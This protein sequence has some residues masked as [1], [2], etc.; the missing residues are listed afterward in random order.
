MC[1]FFQIKTHEKIAANFD[2]IND[3]IRKTVD[4]LIRVVQNS[5]DSEG[6]T[7]A[8]GSNSISTSNS[9]L[10]SSSNSVSNGIERTRS[11]IQSS[12][13]NFNCLRS[14]ERLPGSCMAT[15]LY[16]L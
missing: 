12:S 14:D 11:I 6:E 3:D 9:I 4:N 13:L 7:Q 8:A 1:L 5:A 15:L 2:R 10:Y 16:E